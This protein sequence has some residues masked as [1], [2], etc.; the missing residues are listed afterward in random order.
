MGRAPAVGGRKVG[1]Q[2]VAP[3]AVGN[4]R[5]PVGFVVVT[6]G[7][8]LPEFDAG[9]GQR[10]AVRGRAD[11]AGDDIALADAV[12]QR[13]ARPIEGADLVPGRRRALLCR[14]ARRARNRHQ[15]GSAEYGEQ[16]G[17]DH[18]TSLPVILFMTIEKQSFDRAR[19]C[20][21]VT[22]CF[23]GVRFLGRDAPVRLF[24]AWV[25][26]S[27]PVAA[28]PCPWTSWLWSAHRPA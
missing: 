23:P 25:Q 20:K 7:V 6:G 19:E 14:R 15:G 2:S 4:H 1:F 18:G 16:D 27:L 28:R 10:P 12:A 24:S 22:T 11:S 17:A 5:G 9:A 21:A 13:G 26:R 8:G 3:L